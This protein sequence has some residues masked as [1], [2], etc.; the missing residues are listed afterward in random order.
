MAQAIIDD[1]DN[2][3]QEQVDFQTL[4]SQFADQRD[5]L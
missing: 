5:N 4:L 3:T 2:E 1:Q